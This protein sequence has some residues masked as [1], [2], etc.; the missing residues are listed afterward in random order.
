MPHQSAFVRNHV[1]Y[2]SMGNHEAYTDSGQ[3]ALDD[4]H[5]PMPLEGLTSPVAGPAGEPPERN[6]SYDHGLVHFV[7]F[8]S[9]APGQDGAGLLAMSNGWAG[10]EHLV[11]QAEL[12]TVPMSAFEV[13][14]VSGILVDPATGWQIHM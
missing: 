1:E 6:Y 13:V 10:T 9:T 8:D 3:P 12:N 11:A 14:D 5:V 4:Y 2:Y 7:V